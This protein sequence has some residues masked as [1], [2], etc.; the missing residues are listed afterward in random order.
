MKLDEKIYLCRK[1]AGMSQEDLADALG[2]SRQSVS[3]WETGEANPDVTKIP[4]I[5]NLF[6]V[7]ADWLL[8]DEEE[9][10]PV[11]KTQQ[12]RSWP[13]WVE[14]LP[15]FLGNLVKRFGWLAGLRMAVSGGLFTGIGCLSRVMFRKMLSST[16]RFPVFSPGMTEMVVFDANF[17]G[18]QSNAWSM[19][20]L[21]TG[22]IIGLGIVIMVA[23]IVIA[24][25]L[26]KWGEG[27]EK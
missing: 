15:G 8:S 3:K 16:G 17:T 26:K 6:G 21:F 2:V 9:T 12:D 24:W 7:T 27:S 4:Q 10:A 11:E 22:A 14:N 1:K 13:N 5:A 18:F 25:K 23:G 20:S 19:A